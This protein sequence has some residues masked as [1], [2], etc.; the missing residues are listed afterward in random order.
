M[1][2]LPK[3]IG[4]AGSFASGQ[5]TLA[6]YLEQKYN[7]LRFSTSDAVREV[8]MQKYGSIERPVL[9]KAATELRREQGAGALALQG[10][11]KLEQG[12]YPGVLV[13]GIRSMGELKVIVRAGGIMIFTD[14]DLRLRYERMISRSRDAEVQ[15]TQEQ[16]FEREQSE[17]H[18]GDGDEDFNRRD[19]LAHCQQLGTVVYNDTDID[20]FYRQAEAIFERV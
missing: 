12:K 14:A 11:R 18:T 20:E 8:A 1:N 15:L 13:T 16:F 17:W 5:D 3:V 7:Y 2:T 4:I 9:H 6:R 19:I 10:I